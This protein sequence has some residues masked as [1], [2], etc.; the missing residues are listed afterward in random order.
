[1]DITLS[2]EFKIG[3][4][5]FSID[6]SIINLYDRKNIFYFDRVTGEQVNMLSFLPTVSIKVKI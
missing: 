5:N 1:M 3:F 6:A 2:K 4:A